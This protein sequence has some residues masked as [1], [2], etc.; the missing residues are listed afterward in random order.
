[1]SEARPRHEVVVGAVTLVAVALIVAAVLWLQRAD[2]GRQRRE[3][4]ARFRDVG[5]AKVGQRVLIRGVPAGRLD[6]VELVDGG[7]V[8]VRFKL[9]KEVSLPPDPVVLLGASSLFGEWQAQVASR[10]TVSLGREIDE[11]LEAASD[12]RDVLPG[13]VLPDIAQLTSVAGRI[14]SD[15]ASVAER[16]QSAFT[17]TAANELRSTI[18]NANAFTGT[19]AATTRT[20][21]RNL[22]KLVADLQSTVVALRQAAASLERTSARADSASGGGRMD[23]VVE[24]AAATARDAR[25][26]AA[27][28]RDLATKLALSGDA[29]ARAIARTDTLLGRVNA[30]E[31]T[32]GKLVTD[33]TLH[34]ETAALLREL[35]GLTADIK[36]NPRR[37]VN[38]KLF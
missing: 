5:N 22:D 23:A 9:E 1:M 17:D 8:H 10:G 3:V 34:T 31:G 38:V 11:Q 14:A 32:L 29:L 26:T 25:A 35:R 18:A 15:V 36:A 6:R 4:T 16:V 33:T 20:Q 2:L 19:L 27:N 24:D 7:W 37:Y 21:S 30:G 12:A 13:A 28:L